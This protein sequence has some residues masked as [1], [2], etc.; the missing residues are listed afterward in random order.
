MDK[1]KQE[2]PYDSTP[3][4]KAH[5]ENIKNVAKPILED[6]RIAIATHD[7]SKLKEPEKSC[8]DKYIPI[9]RTEKYGTPKYLEIRKKMLKDGL[10]HH[11]KENRHHPEHFEHGIE[12]MHLV[13][14]LTLYIDWYAASLRSDTS[15]EEGFDKNCERYGISDKLKKI[16]WNTHLYYFR[17]KKGD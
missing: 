17:K 12:D 14:L 9:L 13:D 6:L 7:A 1:E 5:I 3:D 2:I 11:Y 4:T 16:I 10:S 8:Y 15:F